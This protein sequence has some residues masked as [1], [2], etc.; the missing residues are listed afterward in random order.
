VSQQRRSA[1]RFVRRLANSRFEGAFNPY[2]DACADHDGVDAPAIR[3]RNL[4]LVLEA[5]LSSG[6][7]SFWIARDLGYRGGRRTG[8]ALTDD[9]H[10]AAHGG[11][12]GD[13]PLIRATR[14]PAVAERTAT[15]IWQVLRSLERPVFLWTVFPFHPHEPGD[16]MSNR[17]HTRAERLACRPLLIWLLE[18]LRPKTLVAIGRDA[19]IA[20]DDLDIPAQKVRHPSYGGQAEFISGMEAHYGI[21]AAPRAPQGSLF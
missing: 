9:V 1:Q 10:L 11:L 16:A 6:V 15:T 3:R 5:A 18:A 7:D 20:L 21:C 8:L 2:S 17:C 13:L 12:Y 19:Q 4:A 14:G